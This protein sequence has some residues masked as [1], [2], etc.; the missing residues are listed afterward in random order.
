MKRV[1]WIMSMVALFVAAGV[2][3][4]QAPQ[5]APA[6]DEILAKAIEGVEGPINARMRI[7]TQTSV[8]GKE[9][10]TQT[11]ELWLRDFHHLRAEVPG[12]NI[13][14][15]VTPERVVLY[16]GVSGV[17][18]VVPEETLTGFGDEFETKLQEVGI[19]L[20]GRLFKAFAT[21]VE[22]ITITG[23]QKIGPAD[24]WV[25]TVAED[26]LADWADAL[27]IGAQLGEATARS[28][29]I[30]LQKDT[31]DFRGLYIDLSATAPNGIAAAITVYVSI[32]EIEKM[33]ISDEMLNWE[34]PED[35][36]IIEWT[37]DKK[38]PLVM[39]EFQKAVMA[40]LQP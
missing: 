33:D 21:N 36:T 14:T 26:K 15:V 4:A 19:G 3:F 31:G 34:L 32:P 23:E 24:C 6:V 9:Q 2:V 20:P 7:D 13:V 18:I 35:S 25:L 5:G 8:D 28:A 12:Q 17:A 11:Q 16:H 27:S 40:V 1:T 10:P 22:G 37:P 39:Q 29:Q 30:A 38:G